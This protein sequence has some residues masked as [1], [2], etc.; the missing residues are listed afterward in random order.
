MR[1]RYKMSINCPIKLKIRKPKLFFTLSLYYSSM[2]GASDVSLLFSWS[3]TLIFILAAT[4]THCRVLWL[5]DVIRLL[6]IVVVVVELHSRVSDLS[7]FVRGSIYSSYATFFLRGN[8]R[9]ASLDGSKVADINWRNWFAP[10]C[11]WR[12]KL[13]NACFPT[14]LAGPGCN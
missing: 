3:V 8:D 11:C 10:I 1:S 5:Y 9:L 12:F 14:E 7:I 6:E 4:S 2:V 13:R